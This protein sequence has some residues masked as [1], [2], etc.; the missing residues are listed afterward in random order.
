MKHLLLMIVG[1][2]IFSNLSAQQSQNALLKDFTEGTFKIY[3]PDAKKKKF[4]ASK[5]PWP[6]KTVKAGTDAEG[7]P[8]VEKLIIVRAGVIEEEFVPDLKSYPAYFKYASTRALFIGDN[9]FYFDWKNQNALVKYVLAKD[10]FSWSYAETKTKIEAQMKAVLAAQK[11]ERK[12]IA[13][14]KAEAETKAKA[15][16]SLKGKNVKSIEVKWLDNQEIGHFSK[17]KYGLIA[18]LTNGKQLKTSN[19][20]GHTSWEDYTI[21]VQGGEYGEELI[22]ISGNAKEIIGDQLI[23]KASV[24]YQPNVK[25]TSKLNMKYN[26]PV[27]LNFGGKSGGVTGMY[28]SP[29]YRGG[30]GDDVTLQ[31]AMGKNTATGKPY[32]KVQATTGGKTF[33]FKFSKDALL[34]VNAGGGSGSFGRD[35]TQGGNGGDGGDVTLTKG[36]SVGA[37]LN[38]TVNNGAGSGG[39]HQDYALKNGRA[40]SRGRFYNN[41]GAVSLSW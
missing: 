11:G 8:I 20:G 2:F 30:D 16:A 26:A 35:S 21:K 38:I 34:T 36:S 27:F 28:I 41:V 31:A 3:K 4:E 7:N 13:K 6:V 32:V 40:G 18:T 1:F 25:T 33:Y 9:L 15:L 12:V 39:K 29:G 14:G 37:N 23:V 17:V 10:S 5:R 24:K 19:L 22:T